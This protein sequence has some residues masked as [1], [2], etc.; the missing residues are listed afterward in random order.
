VTW[1]L[2]GGL[3]LGFATDFVLEAVGG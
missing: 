1:A 3:F 2:L